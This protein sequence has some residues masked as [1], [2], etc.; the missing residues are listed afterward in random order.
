MFALMDVFWCGSV[1][2]EGCRYSGRGRMG[3]SG[4]QATEW[5]SDTSAV[6]K[7]SGGADGSMVLA[8][9]AGGR[10]G[11]LTESLSFDGSMASRVVV[12]NEGRTGGG[13]VTV[14]GADFGTSRWFGLRICVQTLPTGVG[15]C[16]GVNMAKGAIAFI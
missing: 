12:T 9:T 6:C 13:S 16:A 15:R 14:S 3:Q 4:M 10:G 7:A 5:V 2:S 8:V 1:R 11:S